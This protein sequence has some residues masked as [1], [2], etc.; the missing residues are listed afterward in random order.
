[1]NVVSEAIPQTE[2]LCNCSDDPLSTGHE[3]VMQL[4]EASSVHMDEIVGDHRGDLG[5]PR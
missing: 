5:Q 3:Y 1:M 4:F 2:M